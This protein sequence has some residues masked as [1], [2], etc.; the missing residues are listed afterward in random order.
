MINKLII[1]TVFFTSYVS[2]G[3]AASDKLDSLYRSLDIALEKSETYFQL[4]E[5]KISGLKRMLNE[6]STSDEQRYLLNKD[7]F[8]EFAPY[9][10]DSALNYISRNIVLSQSLNDSY[11]YA[12]EGL[13]FLICSLSIPP[14]HLFL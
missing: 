1:I 3:L 11:R 10:C 8:S 13:L 5:S 12:N 9:Q 4:K 7:I 14:Y 2:V 6:F